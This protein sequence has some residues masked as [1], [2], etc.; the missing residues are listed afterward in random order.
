MTGN[1]N[2]LRHIYKLERAKKVYSVYELIE[3]ET[4]HFPNLIRIE[5]FRGFSR[6][7]DIDKYF[8]VRDTTNWA[9]STKITGLFKTSHPCVFYGDQKTINGKRTIVFVFS[10]DWEWLIIDYYPTQYA[11]KAI[12]ESFIQKYIDGITNNNRGV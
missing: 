1:V 8:R 4:Q 6:A 9:T 2:V 5:D 10:E 11:N 12:R 3:T 7:T